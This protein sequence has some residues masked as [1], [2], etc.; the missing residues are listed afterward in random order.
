MHADCYLE[1][2][3]IAAADIHSDGIIDDPW[4]PFSDYYVAVDTES[5]DLVGTCR[6]IRPS[7]RGFPSFEHFSPSAHALE[8]F[9]QLDPAR[10]SE[11]S[12]LATPRNGM[13]NM[14]IS[15][16]LYGLV[17]RESIRH[18]RAYMLAVMDDRL[19]R[20]MRRWF[21]FP[22]EAIGEP[23]HFMGAWTTPVAMFVPRTIEHLQAV[24]PDALRYFSGDISFEELDSFAID[25]R[26]EVREHRSNV[27]DLRAQRTA[28]P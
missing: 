3:Y 12:A 14:A 9:A 20:I 18:G 10:C 1:A 5:D 28:Y 13:Q 19:L 26:S 25:L 24:N 8:V 21:E 23:V 17:W 6:I 16:A 15:A 4:V 27:I 7:V 11:I 2:G 22:F